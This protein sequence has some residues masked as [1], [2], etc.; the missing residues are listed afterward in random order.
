M[1]CKT[2]FLHIYS[3]VTK[4]RPKRCALDDSSLDW[5][6]LFSCFAFEP[7]LLHSNALVLKLPSRVQRYHGNVKRLILGRNNETLLW[8]P[9]VPIALDSTHLIFTMLCYVNKYE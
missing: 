3:F 2:V 8:S 9:C 1:K 6:L 7:L 4:K 5:E